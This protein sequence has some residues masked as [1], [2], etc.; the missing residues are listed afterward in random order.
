MDIRLNTFSIPHLSYLKYVNRGI[1]KDHWIVP[2]TIYVAL[3]YFAM[4]DIRFILLLMMLFFIGFPAYLAYLYIWHGL[5]PEA[6]FNILEKEILI[7]ED[8]IRLNFTNENIYPKTLSWKM[9]QG[10]NI[11]HD[12][13]ILNFSQSKYLHLILPISTFVCA[14]DIDKMKIFLDTNLSK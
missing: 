8:G 5:K 13:I 3:L 14:T 4:C 12:A 1:L 2:T 9:F 6:R 11:T 7:S 10:Y